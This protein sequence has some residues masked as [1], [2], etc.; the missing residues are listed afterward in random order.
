MSTNAATGT[1]VDTKHA[2]RR[3]LDYA[4][5]QAVL[6]DLDAIVASLDAGTLR[7][8]GNWTPG[9]I[10]DHCARFIG[11]ALDGFDASMPWPMRVVARLFLMKRMLSDAPIPA[12]F[13]LPKSAEQLQP[14]RGVDDR[15]GLERLRWAVARLEAGELMDQPS[16]LLG[17]LT[18]EQWTTLQ[19]KHLELHMSFLQPG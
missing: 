5:W 11:G 2:N 19:R 12:G 8:S 7:T 15:H 18:H 1:P 9:E 4:D 3:A 13:K 17:P 14:E 10:G 6:L 16:P